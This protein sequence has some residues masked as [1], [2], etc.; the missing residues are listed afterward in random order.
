[1]DF[2]LLCKCN[3]ISILDIELLITRKLEFTKFYDL[4]LLN[5]L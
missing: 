2:Q 3:I 5:L 4:I 1:M